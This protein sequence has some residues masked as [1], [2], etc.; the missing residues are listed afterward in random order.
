MIKPNNRALGAKGKQANRAYGPREIHPY[1]RLRRYFPRR[2]KFALR[3]ASKLTSNSRHS[4]AKTSPSGG[5]AVGRRGAFPTRQR[6]GCMVFHARQGGFKC[7]IHQQ[8]QHSDELAT[9][10]G[11]SPF[12]ALRHHLSPAVRGHNKAPYNIL[13]ICGS[14]VSTGLLSHRLRGEG[15]G[16]ATKGGVLFSRPKG[17]WHVFPRP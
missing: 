14:K 10:G 9:S 7:F 16:A 2:G 15:G 11:F 6:R 8:E 13:F 5:G 17:G 3:S 4:A 1:P 12:G